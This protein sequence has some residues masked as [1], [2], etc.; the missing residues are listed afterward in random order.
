MRSRLVLVIA[1][2]VSAPSA[3]GG[4]HL[5]MGE[6]TDDAG[7]GLSTESTAT[8]G[9]AGS[10]TS[11]GTGGATTAGGAG[12]A[13]GGFTFDLIDDMEDRNELLPV[14]P[15]DGRTGRWNTYNDATPGATQWPVAQALFAMSRIDPPR[16]SSTYAART[17]GQGFNSAP[18]GGWA[19]MEL[20][21]IGAAPPP[22]GGDAGLLTENYDAHRYQ[23]ITFY[24]KVGA[25]PQT[26]IRVNL[27]TPQTLPQGGTCMVCYDSFGE[28]VS[29]TTEWQ[30]YFVAFADLQQR[31]IGDHVPFFDA[32]HVYTVTFGFVGP[33]PFDLWIDDIAFYK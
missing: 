11:A 33:A 7:S 5:T 18:S 25:G 6:G 17:Y 24:G 20:S 1:C 29:F 14:P 26:E 22:D 3:C 28:N 2:L 4:Q 27:T 30:Q 32:Y 10:A 13:S 19:S 23:G 8:G 12:G 31:N 15:R 9:S 16:G 21:F